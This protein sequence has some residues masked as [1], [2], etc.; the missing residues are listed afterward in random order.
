MASKSKGRCLTSEA[1]K[2]HLN[3]ETG[4]GWWLASGWSNIMTEKVEEGCIRERL[5]TMMESMP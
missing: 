3:G 4:R 1:Q 5:P 2:D